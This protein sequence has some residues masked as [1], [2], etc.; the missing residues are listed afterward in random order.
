MLGRG[1]LSVDVL[2]RNFD[3]LFRTNSARNRHP[4]Y[5]L[6]ALSPKS[7]VGGTWSR[8]CTAPTSNEYHHTIGEA[9]LIYVNKSTTIFIKTQFLLLCLSSLPMETISLQILY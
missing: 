5:V 8:A 9:V 7:A 6:P 2:C 1:V 4:P 3:I